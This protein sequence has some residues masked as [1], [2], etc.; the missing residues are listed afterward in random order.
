MATAS[1]APTDRP[2][3]QIQGPR[4][5]GHQAQAGLTHGEGDVIGD[6]AQVTGKGELEPGADGVTLHRGDRDRRHLRPDREATLELPMASSSGPTAPAASASIDGSPGA[7][8][9]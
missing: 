8:C 6:H 4:E 2:V 9:G 3:A 7:P 1:W 5:G